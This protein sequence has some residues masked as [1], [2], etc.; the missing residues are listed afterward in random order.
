MSEGFLMMLANKL[1]HIVL[2]LGML[3]M[4]IGFLVASRRDKHKA[5]ALESELIGANKRIELLEAQVCP[6]GHDWKHVSSDTHA[7]GYSGVVFCDMEYVCSRCGKRK[8]ESR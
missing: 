2:G 7:E 3:V 5:M 4:G 1:P 8:V 6:N